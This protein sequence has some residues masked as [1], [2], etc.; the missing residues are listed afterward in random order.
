[1]ETLLYFHVLGKCS[2]MPIVHFHVLI[3][4]YQCVQTR[5]LSTSICEHR[6]I[7]DTNIGSYLSNDLKQSCFQNKFGKINVE[8][9]KSCEKVCVN[10]DCSVSVYTDT[11]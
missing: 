7:T 11:D 3:V 9:F 2:H 5:V 6:Y 10:R 8:S 4:L 1:M